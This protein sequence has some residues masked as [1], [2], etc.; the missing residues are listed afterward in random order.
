MG[1]AWQGIK[2][3][4]LELGREEVDARLWP[5]AAAEGW[6]VCEAYRGGGKASNFKYVAPWGF[7]F[8]S[9]AQSVEAKDAREKATADH[10]EI[11]E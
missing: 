11:L 9:R 4:C 3:G 10:T 1:I 5:G 8:S 7:Y 2:D 6:R